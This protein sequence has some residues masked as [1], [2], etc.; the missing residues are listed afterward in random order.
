VSHERIVHRNHPRR[1]HPSAAVPVR[2]QSRIQVP[3]E[4]PSLLWHRDAQLG[5]LDPAL[6][7]QG[8]E[9]AELAVSHP[10]RCAQGDS[11]TLQDRLGL[12][13]PHLHP[14]G[15]S[16]DRPGTGAPRE[17]PGVHHRLQPP[18]FHRHFRYVQKE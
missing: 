16:V 8:R 18:E 10:N 11:F 14:A 2:V 4:V 1:L 9:R 15:A 12:V 13:P 6:R 5:H 17:G 3:P 7:L